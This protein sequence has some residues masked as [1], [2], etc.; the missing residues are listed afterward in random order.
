MPPSC[1][2]T[3]TIHPAAPFT[4]SICESTPEMGLAS[5]VGL[6]AGALG[7]RFSLVS[8][9]PTSTGALMVGFV[10][11]AGAPGSSPS[12]HEALRTARDMDAADVGLLA[13]AVFVI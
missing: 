11:A 9:L 5:L 8:L 10:V 6:D 13:V 2:T 7:P 1:P 3:R 4:G 12:W